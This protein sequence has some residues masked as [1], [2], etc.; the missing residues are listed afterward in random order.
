MILIGRTPIHDDDLTGNTGTS[1]DNAWKQEFYDQIDAALAQCAVLADGYAKLAAAN[2]FTADQKILKARPQWQGQTPGATDLVRLSQALTGAGFNRLDLTS[3]VT[4]DGANYIADDT[5]KPSGHYLQNNGLHYW[6]HYPVG[7]NPRT[8]GVFLLS[9]DPAGPVSLGL[10]QL[11]FPAAQ[12][13]SADPNTLDDYEEGTWLPTLTFGGAAVGMTYNERAGWYVKIGGWIWAS[14]RLILANKGTSV[15]S[16]SITGLPFADRDA[17]NVG[18]NANYFGAFN[19]GVTTIPA[20]YI[21]NATIT[22]V[23]GAAGGIVIL[24]NTSFNPGSLI[25]ALMYRT[26][27]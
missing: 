11:K 3:N 20:F 13:P 23:M 12:N 5:S 15:G 1:L 18:G 25:G 2:V 7:A 17:G 10:G 9:A 6:I 16:A 4:F 19:A 22:P 26:P 27:T 14:L 24:D 21:T 8:N